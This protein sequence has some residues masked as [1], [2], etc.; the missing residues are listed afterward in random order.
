MKI[1]N[2]QN[3]YIGQCIYCPKPATTKEHIVPSAFGGYHVLLDASCDTCQDTTGKRETFLCEHNFNALRFNRGYFG[4]SRGKRSPDLKVI[5]G[6]TP[7]QAPVRK[8]PLDKA[9]GISIFPVL[10]PPG[11]LLG[12]P[13]SDRVGVLQWHVID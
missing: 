3:K 7:H 12:I 8:L 4:R 2:V 9:P 11:I 6:K 1:P 13:P 5:E 10:P